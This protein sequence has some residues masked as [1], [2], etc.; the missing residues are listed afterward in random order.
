MSHKFAVGQTV[1]LTPSNA[2]NAVVGS[3]E[4]RQLMPES[5]YQKEPRYRIRNMT[6]RHERIVAESDLMERKETADF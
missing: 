2:N 4:I 1:R 5:D 6:E 3:Y